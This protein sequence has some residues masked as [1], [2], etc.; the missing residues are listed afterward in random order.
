RRSGPDPWPA[1]LP[2]PV[3]RLS[4]SRTREES[5]IQSNCADLESDQ[6]L[7]S[8]AV[9]FSTPLSNVYRSRPADELLAAFCVAG[10]HC[11]GC[12]SFFARISLI[13]CLIS[14]VE[15]RERSCLRAG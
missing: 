2:C 6:H 12:S 1:P 4:S 9:H 15:H 3:R 7:G 14:D 11:R 8:V 10:L 13:R 5:C